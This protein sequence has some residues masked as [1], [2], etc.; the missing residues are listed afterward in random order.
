M[1]LTWKSIAIEK[2]WHEKKLFKVKCENFK[3]KVVEN[4]Q[5]QKWRGQRMKNELISKDT[6][7]YSHTQIGIFLSFHL[8]SILSIT[9]SK[10]TSLKQHV[11][12]IH[13]K[14]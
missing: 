2:K 5:E 4:E 3:P 12:T 8:S 7:N 6:S 10:A 14:S 11:S 13:M 9:Q 1:M